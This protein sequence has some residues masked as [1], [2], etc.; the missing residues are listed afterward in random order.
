[1]ASSST[2]TLTRYGYK[3]GENL[4]SVPLV[5][6]MVAPFVVGARG[7]PVRGLF[8]PQLAL[9]DTLQSPLAIETVTNSR[10]QNSGR[11]NAGKEA[12]D[13]KKYCGAMEKN[14]RGCNKVFFDWGVTEF[15]R[16]GG[17][18]WFP[19]RHPLGGTG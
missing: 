14:F 18:T 13:S 12:P 9:W 15:P 7:D 1:M 4:A 8:I 6:V 11:R 19:R 16:K 3:S 5:V 17:V 10:Y 2:S